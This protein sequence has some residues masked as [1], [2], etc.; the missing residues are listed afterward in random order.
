VT[1]PTFSSQFVSPLWSVP[2]E[3]GPVVPMFLSCQ[4]KK[5]KKKKNLFI[6]GSFYNGEAF[7]SFQKLRSVKV[8]NNNYKTNGTLT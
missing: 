7:I 8:N 5:K 2:R 1:N 3:T 6:C 4:K